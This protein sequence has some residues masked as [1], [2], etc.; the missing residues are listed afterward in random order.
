MGLS[1]Y[2]WYQAEVGEQVQSDGRSAVLEPPP[3]GAGNEGLHQ[4]LTTVRQQLA[5]ARQ[6]LES[7]RRSRSY[8][9]ARRVSA[10]IRSLR[11]F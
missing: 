3:G 5:V 7:I 4:E 11:V 2:R 1:Y 9:A 8:R 6:E 10:L